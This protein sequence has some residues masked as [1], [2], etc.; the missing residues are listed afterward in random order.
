MP[1]GAHSAQ[2]LAAARA[3]DTRLLERGVQVRTVGQDS[4]RNDLPTL[5]HA[6]FLT[7]TGAQFRTA[8]LLP[9]RMILIDRRCALV[10]VD[11]SDTRKGALCVNAAGTIAS[12]MALF[13]QVWQTATPLGA[14]RTP[15]Q[16]GLTDPERAL[17]TLLA[18]GMTDEA[19]ATR[20]GVSTR[21]ARR[22]MAALMERLGAVSRFEAGLKAAQQGWL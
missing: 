18:R 17:L 22:T 6:Q 11:P 12:L 10:P 13:E 15:D 5:A 14:D 2:A 3:N 7:D 19:A 16:Q 8:P 20:L 9:P 21:T 4:L 1:G